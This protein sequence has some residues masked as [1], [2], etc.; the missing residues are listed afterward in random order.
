MSTGYKIIFAFSLQS[1][2]PRAIPVLSYRLTIPI[3]QL[4][5]R[6]SGYIF[7]FSTRFSRTDTSVEDSI[8]INDINV[9]HLNAYTGAYTRYRI[10]PHLI[11]LIKFFL[12]SN[13]VFLLSVDV[14]LDALYDYYCYR[15]K[16]IT[17]ISTRSTFKYSRNILYLPGNRHYLFI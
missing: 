7:I 1:L 2:G 10:C 15:Y 9:Q 5:S 16:L 3:C 12:I 13:F 6:V 11:L 14:M 4:R 17:A 8:L